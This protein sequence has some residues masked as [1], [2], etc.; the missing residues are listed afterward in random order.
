MRSAG[1]AIRIL[2]VRIEGKKLLALDGGARWPWQKNLH[3]V[4]RE[5]CARE[6]RLLE[7]NPRPILKRQEE[8]PL[9]GEH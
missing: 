6:S 2:H 4:R 5:N 1:K 3:G 9:M 7:T 8:T